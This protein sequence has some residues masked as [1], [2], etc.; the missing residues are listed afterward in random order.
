MKHGMG[1]MPDLPD[2]RDYTP[3]HEEVYPILNKRKAEAKNATLPPSVDNR[4]FCS[5]IEDQGE[6]GSCTAHAGVGMYEYMMRRAQGK[7]LD[8]SRRFLYKVT[9]KF[10]RLTGDT[11]AELR[12]TMGAMVIFGCPPESYWEYD[13]AKFDAEPSSFCYSFAQAFQAVKYFRLDEPNQTRKETLALIKGYL[14]RGYPVMFGFTVYSSLWENEQT[15]HIPFPGPGDQ[16]EGGHAVMAVGYDDKMGIASTIGG[17]LIRNSWG[18]GWG[19]D[20]YGWM[21]YDYVLRGLAEDFW[22]MTKAEWV[23]TKQFDE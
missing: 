11:G 23:D 13:Q 9:R 8:L 12:S 17:L 14:A 6:I 5:P 22:S 1:W 2:I 21:P 10:M 16:A 7:H 18:K 15:G 20:G 4:N 3:G 19:L